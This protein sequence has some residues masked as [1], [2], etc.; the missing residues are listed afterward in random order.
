[1]IVDICTS[2]LCIYDQSMSLLEGSC[3]IVIPFLDLS[4]E[5]QAEETRLHT[6]SSP[7]L[8]STTGLETALAVA[9][10]SSFSCVNAP[11]SSQ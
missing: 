8:P 3:C 11:T 5:L 1:M 2:S 10:Q 9:S 4:V 6:L 7:R